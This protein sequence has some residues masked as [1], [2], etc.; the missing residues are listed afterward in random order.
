MSFTKNIVCSWVAKPYGQ[1]QPPA[2]PHRTAAH[3]ST[4]SSPS[5]SSQHLVNHARKPLST[6]HLDKLS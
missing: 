6:C 4:I 2:V 3:K 1:S 5:T